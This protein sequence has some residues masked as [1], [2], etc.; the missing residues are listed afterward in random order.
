MAKTIEWMC[1]HCGKKESHSETH[2]RPQPGK[3]PRKSTGGPH[4]WVKNRTY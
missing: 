1:T 2:G 4:T 3:C